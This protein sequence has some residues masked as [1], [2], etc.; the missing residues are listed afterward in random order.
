MSI[1]DKIQQKLQ[2]TLHPIHLKVID[3]SHLHA[4]HQGN[5]SNGIESHFKVEIASKKFD[6]LSKLK[7]H[8]LVYQLLK[9]EIQ[10]LHA[11][12]LIVYGEAE[13]YAIKK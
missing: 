4:G 11:I 9:E 3:Q 12:T 6:S 13:F 5:D 1:A 8:Q 10:L 7:R 2:D